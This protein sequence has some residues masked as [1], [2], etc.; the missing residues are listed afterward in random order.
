MESR[1]SCDQ[2]GLAKDGRTR[3]KRLEQGDCLAKTLLHTFRFD[4]SKLNHDC[5]SL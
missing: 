3:W 5:N 1:V 2:M 4:A